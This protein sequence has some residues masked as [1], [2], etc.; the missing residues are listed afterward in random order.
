MAQIANHAGDR[1]IIVDDSLVPLLA[2]V[3]GELPDVEAFIVN[4]AGDASALG[5]RNGRVPV[6][7]YQ[8]LLAAEEPEDYN[9]PDL[10]ERDPSH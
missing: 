4:G 1:I 9:W 7:R 5:G 10:D 3:S 8:E 2:K 6:L